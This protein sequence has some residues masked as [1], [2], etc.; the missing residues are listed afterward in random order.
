MGNKKAIPLL[1]CVKGKRNNGI[2]DEILITEIWSF[3][4]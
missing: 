2:S 4:R 3:I 1:F